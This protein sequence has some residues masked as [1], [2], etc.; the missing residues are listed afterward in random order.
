MLKC[1]KITTTKASSWMGSWAQP[2]SNAL[3]MMCELQPTP[4]I[5]RPSESFN[6]EKTFFWPERKTPPKFSYDLGHEIKFLPGVKQLFSIASDVSEMII[7]TRSLKVW[8]PLSSLKPRTRIG[9]IFSA[10][11]LEV[12]VIIVTK[13]IL[14]SFALISSSISGEITWTTAQGKQIITWATYTKIFHLLCW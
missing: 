3:W 5:W 6:R 10:F 8:T 13:F 7:F 12:S 4:T 1:L 2:A 11:L 14:L 9:S